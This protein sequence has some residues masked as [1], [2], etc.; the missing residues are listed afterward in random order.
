MFCITNTGYRFCR[1]CRLWRHSSAGT[2][3][4]AT[5]SGDTAPRETFC[6]PTNG[7]FSTT[8]IRAGIFLVQPAHPKLTGGWN[9][10]IRMLRPQV[11]AIPG[12]FPFPQNLPEQIPPLPYQLHRS[13][14]GLSHDKRPAG[15]RLASEPGGQQQSGPV[16]M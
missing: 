16:I 12:I 7:L 10:Q 8:A 11:L 13:S 6:Y 15:S 5:A 14:K 9:L 2:A 4:F 3:A 1:E